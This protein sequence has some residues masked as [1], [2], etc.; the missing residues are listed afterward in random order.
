MVDY[1]KENGTEVVNM[2]ME[3][4]KLED[5]IKITREEAREEGVEE[6]LEKG[7]E[8]GLEKGKLETAR[9][10]KAFGLSLDDIAAMTLLPMEQ[11]ER[12]LNQPSD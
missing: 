9:R 2:L 4:Y 1:L 3:E 11:L 7:L 6:G 10:L 8:I 12:E 5:E